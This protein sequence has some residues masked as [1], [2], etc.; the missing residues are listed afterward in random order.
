VKDLYGQEYLSER[1]RRYRTKTKGAQEAHEAIRPAGTRMRTVDELGLSGLERK[2]YDLIWKRT[3]ATQMAEARQ[4]HLTIRIVADDAEFRASGKVLVFAGFFRA[5]VEGSDD[6]EAALEDQEILLP[7][8]EEGDTL[9]CR[10]LEAVSHETRPPSRYTE[11]TLVKA[12]E[13]EGIGRPST[14]APIISKIQNR[15][16]C[17]KS[18]K[19][20]VPT[21]TAFAVTHLL[22]E[23]FPDLVDVG[24]T[25]RMEEALDEIARGEI[26]WRTYLSDFYLGDE[27]LEARLQEREDAIDPREASTLELQNLRPRVR[28]GKYGPYLELEIEGERVTA[29]VPEGVA[30]ADLADDAAMK[31]LERKAGGPLEVTQDPETGKPVYLMTGPYGPYVQVGESDQEGGK[32][33][34]TSLPEGLEFE[35]VTPEIA[36]KLASMP[37]EVGR[38]PDDDQPVKVGI[39]R[40]G[41]YVVHEGEF[42]SLKKSDD[43]LDVSLD[44][45]LELLAEPKRGRRRQSKKLEDLGAHPDDGKPVAVYDGRYGPYVKHDGTNASLPKETDPDDVTLE[46]ALQLLEEKRARS[47]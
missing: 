31:I 10:D 37:Y 47:S 20:L 46:D 9:E 16:Y 42:R 25:A 41:P 34:R 40:Y 29:S 18:G 2:L 45:A 21:W 7:D 38:H 17:E 44:R 19:Q 15:G 6:P 36:R 26:D 23:H 14:Y 39:G 3:V 27:G 22:E 28:I 35:D 30:P 1:P 5:Y 4:R 12:L 11:A 33:K 43:V 8:V 13:S 24:F 32:P